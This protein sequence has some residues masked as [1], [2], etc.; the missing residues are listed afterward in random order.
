[1][2]VC[3]GGY[4]TTQQPIKTQID[5]RT[6]KTP[7]GKPAYVAGPLVTGVA[8]VDGVTDPTTHKTWTK[9]NY[10]WTITDGIGTLRLCFDIE[11]L[12]AGSGIPCNIAPP[13]IW[14]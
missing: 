2:Y 11:G 12:G 3:H 7:D 1:M 14:N 6:A 13:K 4:Y 10:Y 5:C 8:E 9:N